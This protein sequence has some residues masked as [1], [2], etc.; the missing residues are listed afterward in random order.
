MSTTNKAQLDQPQSEFR[1]IIG[2]GIVLTALKTQ[3][4]KSVRFVKKYLEC[5]FWTI[6]T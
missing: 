2:I 3:N 4:V 6:S 5:L 1:L